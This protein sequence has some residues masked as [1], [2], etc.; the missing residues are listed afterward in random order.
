MKYVLMEGV[1]RE[2][3]AEV[4]KTMA[5]KCYAAAR[6]MPANSDFSRAF[7]I[8]G[9]FVGALGNPTFCDSTD[10][11][12]CVYLFL[13]AT[14]GLGRN[15][16]EA[17]ILMRFCIDAIRELDSIMFRIREDSYSESIPVL[18]FVDNWLACD[19]STLEDL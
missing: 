8:L 9:S 10:F 2:R 16:K 12:K 1:T 4:S 19:D 17:R 18:T 11:R 3:A 14:Q 5:E 13:A 7:R 15:K 6:I